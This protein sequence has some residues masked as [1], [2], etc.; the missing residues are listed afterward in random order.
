M[1]AIE[2]KERLTNLNPFYVINCLISLVVMAGFPY[3]MSPRE[4][5]TSLGVE[6]IGIF[7][8]IIYGWLVA[9]DIVWPSII[10]LV[11]L[12]L[13]DYTTVANAFK[14]GFGHNNVMLMLFF[15]LFTNIISS[16]GITEYIARWMTS[17]KFAQ[18]KPYLMAMM[19]IA[20]AVVL[21]F[22]VTATAACLV[23]FPLVKAI[24]RI[25]GL[26]PGNIWTFLMLSGIVYV[27][28]TS[29]ILLPYK[30]L[31]LIVFSNYAELG[32]DPLNF[33]AYM[34]IVVAATIVAGIVFLLTC[35][36][37]VKPDVTNIVARKA[38]LDEMPKLT[39]YQKMIFAYFVIVIALIMIPNFVPATVGISTLLKKIGTPGIV[40]SAVVFYTAVRFKE[41]KSIME[42]FS[43]DIAWGVIFILACALTISGAVQAE[44]TGIRAWMAQMVA[45]LVEGKSPYMLTAIVCFIGC[46][47]TNIANNQAVAAIFTP[48]L[49]SIGM[50]SGGN[51]PTLLTCMLASVNVGMITPP[52]SATGS[53]LHGDLEWA[54]GKRA[55]YFGALWSIF[56]YLIVM[57]IMYP[58]GIL[59]L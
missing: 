29:Y 36:Y 56:N 9:G 23:L 20:A 42:L 24:S 41:G 22:M 6:I 44:E 57:L 59:L 5:L 40:A 49:L 32:G 37:I 46:C 15:F 17:R 16:A 19:I 55:Y 4:P 7:L 45:P 52:A 14:T 35:K 38:D 54:G 3:V 10:G 1:I 50:T 51:V 21:F 43:K 48:I 25:Y 34:S 31:P 27:G 33:P 30:S 28:S 47:L 18:G 53:L 39:T 58:L 26:K 13:T 8:G 2:E 12:G 11:M